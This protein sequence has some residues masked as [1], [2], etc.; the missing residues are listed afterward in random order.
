[1]AEIAKMQGNT[2]LFNWL[3]ATI[4]Y[5]EK[6]R[7]RRE[8]RQP[9][10]LIQ[11]KAVIGRWNTLILFIAFGVFLPSYL[12]STLHYPMLNM[13]TGIDYFTFW[14]CGLGSI[15]FVVGCFFILLGFSF[16]YQSAIQAHS[17]FNVLTI[18][19][20]IICLGV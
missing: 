1:M 8:L 6:R 16:G 12:F 4:D 7:K 11:K 13:A 3:K 19:M 5:L 17:I 18:M 9:T 20:V 15:Y 2:K 14:L 10:I